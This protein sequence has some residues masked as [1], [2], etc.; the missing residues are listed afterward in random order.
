MRCNLFGRGE[1]CDINHMEIYLLV[2]AVKV[3]VVVFVVVWV[4]C[5]LQLDW[6]GREMY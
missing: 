5:A 6:E 4:G 3:E 2:G 1:R